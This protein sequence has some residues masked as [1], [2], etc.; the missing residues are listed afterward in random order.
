MPVNP[1][2][3]GTAGEALEARWSSKDALLYAVG[4]GA[5]AID[6]T[7]WELEFTT[8][9]TSGLPQRILPTF[10][11]V[12]AAGRG[13][14]A[15]VGTWDPALLVHGEQ[16]VELHAPLPVEGHVSSVTT[17]TG[18][19]DKGSG[20]VVATET[21]ATDVASGEALFTTRSSAFI[22][23]EGGFGGDR[24]AAARTEPPGRDPDHRVG[25]ATRRD[26]ALLYRLSGDRN[27]LHTDPVFAALGGFD[28]PILHGLCTFGFTGRALLHQLCGSD[29]DRFVAMSARFSRPVLPGDTLTVSIWDLGGGEARFRT[30]A[31]A[32]VVMDSGRFT[33]VG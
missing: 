16:S 2:A 19:Y 30:E 8:E 31:A 25:Y 14:L 5:G 29:P 33:Y 18:V 17:I 10:P 21:V 23:G 15:K 22:R 9:N 20:A 13:V 7:G 3:V 26:Q 24:G 32:G 11:V 1:D 4:V 28:R 6:P 27:P 12:V